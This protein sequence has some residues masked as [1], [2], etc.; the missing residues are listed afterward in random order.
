MFENFFKYSSP[1]DYA[2][3]LINNKNRDE[4]KENIEDVEN[5]ILPLKYRIEGMSEKEKKR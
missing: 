4:N 1:A 2:K 5:R 3:T